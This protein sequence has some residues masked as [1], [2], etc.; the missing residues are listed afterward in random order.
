MK[1]SR[2]GF[3]TIVGNSPDCPIVCRNKR[4][5][6]RPTVSG[7]WI[8]FS[9]AGTR[10]AHE[11]QEDYRHTQEIPNKDEIPER[12]TILRITVISTRSLMRGKINGNMNS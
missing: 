12:R 8:L 9:T 2:E 11:R 10:P 6:F 5:S 7:I 4:F 3:Q 1:G